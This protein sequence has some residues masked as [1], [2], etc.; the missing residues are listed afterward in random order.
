MRAFLAKT[1]ELRR[2]TDNEGDVLSADG[3]AAALE[4]GRKLE[5]DYAVILSSGAQRA[6]QAAAC[7]LAGMGRRVPGG[8]RVDTRFRSE[9]EE[10]WKGAY[11]RAGAGDLASYEKAD[12]DLVAKESELFAAALRDL[13]ETLGDG[14]RAL[15]VGHSPML[16]AAVYGLCGE[17]IDPLSKGAGVVVMQDDAGYRTDGR[18]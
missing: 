13:M 10:R 14:E 4:I 18:R 1:V 7:F 8:V 15:V 5:S 3:I 17:I 6:T 2:H 11:E 16:E 12:P 9:V